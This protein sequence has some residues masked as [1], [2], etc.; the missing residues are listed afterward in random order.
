MVKKGLQGIW[1]L[2]YLLIFIFVVIVLIGIVFAVAPSMNTSRIYSASNTT[3]DELQGYCNAT[4]ADANNVS[5]FYEWYK[6]GAL[7]SYGSLSNYTGEA[8]QVG[9]LTNIL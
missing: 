3:A 5:Y 4:D 7:F 6:D 8:T 2:K 9:Y 1:D